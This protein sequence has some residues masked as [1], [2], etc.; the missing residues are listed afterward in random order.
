M[1]RTSKGFDMLCMLRPAGLIRTQPGDGPSLQKN[2]AKLLEDAI[3][4]T[5]RISSMETIDSED[6]VETDD[7]KEPTSKLSQWEKCCSSSTTSPTAQSNHHQR[8]KKDVKDFIEQD[9]NP[10]H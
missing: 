9:F 5:I 10:E 6:A 7:K 1:Q 8:A 2:A 3:Y 4:K